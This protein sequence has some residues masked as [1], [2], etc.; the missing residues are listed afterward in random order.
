MKKD[1]RYINCLVQLCIVAL[2]Y[3]SHFKNSAAVVVVF[4]H[5]LSKSAI[6]PQFFFGHVPAMTSDLC[7]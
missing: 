3:F 4:I 5:T 2:L 6:W 1:Q 7:G